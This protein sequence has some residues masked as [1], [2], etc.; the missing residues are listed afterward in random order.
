AL[1]APAPEPTPVAVQPV[2]VAA[3]SDQERSALVYA[4]LNTARLTGVRGTGTSARVLMNERVFRLND[5][6]DTALGLRLSG[7]QPNLMVFTDAQGKT[8]EKP[9]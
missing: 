1:A 6:V 8:Y 9:Y 2:N 5:I 7:V 3:L 4:F